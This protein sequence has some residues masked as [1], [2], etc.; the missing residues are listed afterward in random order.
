MFIG[1]IGAPNKGKSTLF[2]A[3]TTLDV[4][5]AEH[6]FTT[7]KPNMGSTY[8]IKKCPD[9]DLNLKCKPKNS[10]CINGNR[11]IPIKIVDVAGLVPEASSGKGMGNQFLNDLSGADALILVVDISGETD[12]FGNPCKNHDSFSDVQFIQ[13]ELIKWLSG[14]ITSH[15]SSLSKSQDGTN[16]LKSILSSFKATDTQIKT[17]AKEANV[18]LSH[19]SWG[20]ES[21]NKFAEQFIKLNKPLVVVANKLDKS[22]KEKLDEL[23]NKLTG[24]K[25][26]GCSAA[27]ELALRKA[28]N[29]GAISYNMGDSSFTINTTDKEKLKA[30]EYIKKYLEKNHDTGVQ[31]TI[32]YV[33]EKLLNQI[34][35]YPVENENKFTDHFGNVLPDAILIKQGSTAIELAAKIHTEIAE[36]MIYAVDARTK[37]R[38]SKEYI[39]KDNDIIKIV[40]AAK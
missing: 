26:I 21:I 19:I 32:N 17:A 6:P 8:F 10:L 40:S 27:I 5:I 28:S 18:S 35:V 25:V 39:L 15:I 33:V 3:I 22:S 14:I 1:L 9:T 37:N 7:I 34:V 31:S 24:I 23:S 13:K 12:E 11:R 30:L 16:A 2:S 36:K 38:V 29:S 4:E 20:E